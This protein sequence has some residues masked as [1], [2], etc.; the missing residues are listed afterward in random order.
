[1]KK[2]LFAVAAVVLMAV[3][4][5]AG[6]IKIHDWPCALVPQEVATVRVTMDV[7][8]WVQVVQQDRVIKLSQVDIHTYQGQQTYDIRTNTCLTLS[9]SIS[10]TG[11]VPGT[12]GC[13]ID[14][15]QINAGTTPVVVRA[16][17]TNANLANVPGGSRDVHVANLTIR[18]VPR[19]CP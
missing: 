8:Y 5:Q 14:P 17:L 16:T 12:Y 9:C 4:A 7:G 13:S 19:A 2:Q 15:A 11:Q 10:P 3:V 6:E 18:V 1:M